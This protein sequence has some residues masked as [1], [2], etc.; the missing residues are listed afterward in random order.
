M[1]LKCLGIATDAAAEGELLAGGR[2]HYVQRTFVAQQLL[3]LRS[4]WALGQLDLGYI[5]QSLEI[6]VAGVTEVCGS[7]AE[8][9]R[10]RAAVAALVLQEIGAM[11][12]THLCPG[13]IRATAADQLLR[14][15]LLANFRV[16]ARLAAVVRFLAFKAHIIGISIHCQ[17]GHVDVFAVRVFYHALVFDPG[18][19]IKICE[20]TKNL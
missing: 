7:K 2:M 15:E 16:T 20:I 14:I 6:V 8:E 12:R 5:G 9:Y 19:K 4:G 18:P 10:H 3:G 1:W 11:L 17:L 13:H